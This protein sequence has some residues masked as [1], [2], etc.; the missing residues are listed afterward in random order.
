[1]RDALV[2][3][4]LFIF[5]LLV[6]SAAICDSGLFEKYGNDLFAFLRIFVRNVLLDFDLVK[7]STC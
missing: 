7:I 6:S 4:I 1:M 3:R 2:Q 5:I